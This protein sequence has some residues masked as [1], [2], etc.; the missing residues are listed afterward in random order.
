MGIRQFTPNIRVAEPSLENAIRFARCYQSAYCSDAEL[1]ETVT[2]T[3]GKRGVDGLTEPATPDSIYE[4]LSSPYTVALE[5]PDPTGDKLPPHGFQIV[6]YAGTDKHSI[7]AMRQYLLADAFIE[8][9]LTFADMRDRDE[10]YAVL[11]AGNIACSVEFVAKR[12]RGA[13][14][15]LGLASYQYVL[16]HFLHTPE[17]VIVGKCLSAVRIG[18]HIDPHG[19]RP[20][21]R[22]SERL[23]LRPIAHASQSRSLQTSPPSVAELV[24]S[25]YFGRPTGIASLYRPFQTADVP[26]RAVTKACF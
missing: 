18:D 1:I 8:D 7:A 23:G 19:N 6:R 12:N 9:E 13:G 25:L 3:D 14:I 2:S 15:A 10:F 4:L 11:A 26:L 17:S 24:F 21:R 22:I 16:D 20:I 5:I